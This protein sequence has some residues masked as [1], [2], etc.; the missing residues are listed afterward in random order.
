MRRTLDTLP[1]SLDDTYERILREIKKPNKDHALRL[2]QCLVVA[3]RPL[4]V[5]ELAEVLAVNFDV[6][7]GIPTLNMSWRWEDQEQALLSSC[8][9]LISIIRGNRNYNSIDNARVVQF[10]HFSVKEFLTSPRLATPIRDVSHYYIGLEPAHTIMAQACLSVL[11]RSD[12]RVEHYGV[13][14]NS[15]LASYAAEFWVTHAQFK[16][17]SSNLRRPME[18]LFD[19]DR[20]YFSSWLKL[21][22]IDTPLPFESPF[23]AISLGHMKSPSGPIYY[24]AL[25]GFRDLAEHLIVKH[26]QGVNASGGYYATPCVAALAGRHFELAHLLFCNGSSVN[27]RGIHENSPLHAACKLG[28]YPEMIRI[29]LKY[30]A[31]INAQN[32]VGATPLHWAANHGLSEV[33]CILLEQGADPNISNNNDHATPLHRAVQSES[34][35]TVRLFLEHGV[36]LDAVDQMGKTALQYAQDRMYDEIVTLFLAHGGNDS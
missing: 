14:N 28:G 12:D 9:S 1:E 29:L 30:G 11:L 22:D 6:E 18:C 35:A 23:Y 21:H 7:D 2:L 19:V 10:S 32:D 20:P 25:C 5:E 8:S 17:V 24:A 13:K 27:A 31:D 15:P 4:R 34:A 33:V 26:P 36:D 3:T 16:D